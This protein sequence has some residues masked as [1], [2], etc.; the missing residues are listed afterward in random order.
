MSTD[1]TITY[2]LTAYDPSNGTSVIRAMLGK[3]EVAAERRRLEAQGMTRIKVAET[4]NAA[5]NAG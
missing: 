5:G 4:R 2:T 1:K 3:E